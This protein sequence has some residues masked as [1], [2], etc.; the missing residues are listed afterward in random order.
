MAGALGIQLGGRNYYDGVPQDRL[1]MGDG[2]TSLTPDH[3][4]QATRIMVVTGVLGL[5]FALFSLWQS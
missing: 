5:I 4:A 3:I 1:L 2:T